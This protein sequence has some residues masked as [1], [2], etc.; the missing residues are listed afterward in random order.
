MTVPLSYRKFH[1]VK[2][3]WKLIRL[4]FHDFVF[5]DSDPIVIIND[6]KI[7][8][9]IKIFAGRD[10]SVKILPRETF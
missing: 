2:F 10:K 9:R 5:T 8:L 3:S 1:R 6:V 4:S 7:V